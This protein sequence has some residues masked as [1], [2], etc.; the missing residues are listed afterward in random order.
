MGLEHTVLGP[1]PRVPV[2]AAKANDKSSVYSTLLLYIIFLVPPQLSL[3]HSYHTGSEQNSSWLCVLCPWGRS[4]G[5]GE[6]SSQPGKAAN[7]SQK[8]PHCEWRPSVSTSSRHHSHVEG[9]ERQGKIAHGQ[10]RN[11]QVLCG[12]WGKKPI[13]FLQ[14]LD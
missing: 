2:A 6:G 8:H 9:I 4:P 7:M 14:A 10:A 5:G 12:R 3:R 1:F 11:R 13:W